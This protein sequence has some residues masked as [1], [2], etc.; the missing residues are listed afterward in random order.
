MLK[1]EILSH[2]LKSE[3]LNYCNS[4][5]YRKLFPCKHKEWTWTFIAIHSKKV[6]I[7]IKIFTQFKKYFLQVGMIPLIAVLIVLGAKDALEDVQRYKMD[8]RIN[9]QSVRVFVAW[10]KFLEN[11][12]HIVL[13]C[14]NID[15]AA[16]S[17]LL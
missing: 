13:N 6:E 4:A 1:E 9:N 10:V 17:A 8:R 11:I 14:N 15:K 7:K 5:K 2:N 16:V 12:R 3:L